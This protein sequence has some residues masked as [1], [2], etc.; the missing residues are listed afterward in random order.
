MSETLLGG[1]MYMVEA[2]SLIGTF[3]PRLDPHET[4]LVLISTVVD[5][6]N[7]WLTDTMANPT[8]VDLRHI[9]TLIIKKR[10]FNLHSNPSPG[11]SL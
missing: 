9:P 8:A 4:M 2:V 11:S 5:Y 1:E 3:V 10:G 6:R 7:Y